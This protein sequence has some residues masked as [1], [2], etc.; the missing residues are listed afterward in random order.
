[1]ETFRTSDVGYCVAHAVVSIVALLLMATYVLWA[2]GLTTY[3]QSTLRGQSGSLSSCGAAKEAPWTHHDYFIAPA[4]GAGGGAVTLHFGRFDLEPVAPSDSSCRSFDGVA[5]GGCCDFVQVFDGLT[6]D[7]PL[8]GV[9]CGTGPPG[10]IVA[11]GAAMLVRWRADGQKHG[12]GWSAVYTTDA[13]AGLPF[14]L[15]PDCPRA[16][17]QR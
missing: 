1:M 6:K 16:P 14:P 8:L 3:S 12:T 15:F 11:S 7:A 4:E 13:A 10:R 17:A 2:G 5:T 9:F